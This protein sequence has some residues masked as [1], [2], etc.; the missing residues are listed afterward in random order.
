MRDDD[1][2]AWVVM[3]ACS[4]LV[5]LMIGGY[6]SGKDMEVKAIQHG[7]ARYN[8]FDARFEW[9]DEYLIMEGN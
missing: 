9:Q 1:T 6:L 7:A 5:G 8:H 2:M 4:F 3:G